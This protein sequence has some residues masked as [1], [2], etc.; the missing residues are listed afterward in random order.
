MNN[1]DI[2]ERVTLFERPC[3]K[4]GYKDHWINWIIFGKCHHCELVSKH[5]EAVGRGRD[6]IEEEDNIPF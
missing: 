4:A 6:T 1:N 3:E 2:K 5:P